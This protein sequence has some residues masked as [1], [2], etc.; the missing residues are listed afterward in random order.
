MGGAPGPA[1]R[2]ALSELHVDPRA[3]FSLVLYDG[4]AEIFLGRD[5]FAGKLARLD[6]ILAAVGPRGPSALRAVHLEG[7]SRDR[8]AVKLAPAPAPSSGG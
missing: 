5:D 2:P 8:I 3:G 7:P 1:T 4:G 6:E